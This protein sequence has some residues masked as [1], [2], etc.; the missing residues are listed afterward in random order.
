MW[1]GSSFLGIGIWIPEWQNAQHSSRLRSVQYDADLDSAGSVTAADFM[2]DC[3]L[4][5]AGSDKTNHLSVKGANKFHDVDTTL[6]FI[7]SLNV[8][9]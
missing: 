6:I 7:V 8:K 3:N 4:G 1:T 2:A 5:W 9:T